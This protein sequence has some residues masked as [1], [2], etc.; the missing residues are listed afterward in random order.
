MGIF[1]I[2]IKLIFYLQLPQYQNLENEHITNTNTFIRTVVNPY[3]ASD[4]YNGENINYQEFVN[5]KYSKVTL[6]LQFQMIIN[7][8][9]FYLQFKSYWFEK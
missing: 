1:I 6:K 9:K 5:N 7:F 3:N 8:F 2:S 4:G